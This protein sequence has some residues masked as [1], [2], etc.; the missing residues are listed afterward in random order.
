MH[1][2]YILP[3]LHQAKAR[4]FEELGEVLRAN[5]KCERFGFTNRYPD[6]NKTNN[7]QD[8]MGELSDL[9]YA[10]ASFKKELLELDIWETF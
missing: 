10:L 7:I 9:E 8:L 3:G 4:F 2:E 6:N 1:S 5:G